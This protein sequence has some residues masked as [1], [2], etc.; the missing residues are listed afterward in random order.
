MQPWQQILVAVYDDGLLITIDGV[1][2][3]YHQTVTQQLNMA[4]EL[5]ARSQKN[6]KSQKE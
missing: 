5:I 3:F 6:E 4:Q 2:Y 1:S